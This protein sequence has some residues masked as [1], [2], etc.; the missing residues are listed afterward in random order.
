MM[1]EAG[2]KRYPKIKNMSC[3]GN[4]KSITNKNLQ[5]KRKEKIFT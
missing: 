3:S 4:H 5:K 2:I 1:M